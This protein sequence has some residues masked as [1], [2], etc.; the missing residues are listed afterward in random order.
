MP[1]AKRRRGSVWEGKGPVRS[2]PGGPSLLYRLYV[3]SLPAEGGV[4]AKGKWCYLAM[5][6]RYHA[7]DYEDAKVHRLFGSSN[8]AA[9][10]RDGVGKVVGDA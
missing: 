9:F 6:L 1:C 8:C 3:D 5:Y 10:T 4:T 7:S 2:V